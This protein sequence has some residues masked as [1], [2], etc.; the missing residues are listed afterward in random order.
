MSSTTPKSSILL[1]GGN[2]NG[3]IYI[4]RGCT[5]V[6]KSTHAKEKKK[7]NPC[8]TIIC[9]ADDYFKKQG[10]YKNISGGIY[11]A[12]LKCQQKFLEAIKKKKILL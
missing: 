4:L 6:G 10:T 2:K 7:E 3:K 5:G 11:K 9:S 12:H 8:G 1:S